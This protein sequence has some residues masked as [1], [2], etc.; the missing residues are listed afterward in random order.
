[1]SALADTPG[2]HPRYLHARSDLRTAQLLSR[3]R[4]EPNVAAR[5]REMDREI[6]A[7]IVETDHAIVL[8]RK[9]MDDHPRIDASMDRTG[10]FRKMLELLQAARSDIAREEDNPSAVGWRDLAY[11]HVDAAINFLK[12]AARDARLGR[13]LGW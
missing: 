9:D 5:L 13:E 4:E 8:D 11:R 1:M 7:A 6:E 2:R 12:R 3:V 10:R